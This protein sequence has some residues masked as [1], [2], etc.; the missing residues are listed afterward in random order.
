MLS[1]IR[2]GTSQV[3]VDL[4]STSLSFLALSDREDAGQ[5][6]PKGFHTF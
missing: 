1:D 2:L 3:V 5:G 4:A 6:I